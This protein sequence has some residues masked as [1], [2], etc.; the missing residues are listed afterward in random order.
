MVKME[1]SPEFTKSTSFHVDNE[2]LSKKDQGKAPKKSLLKSN[3]RMRNKN[4]RDCSTPLNTTKSETG[5]M[6]DVSGLGDSPDTGYQSEIKSSPGSFSDDGSNKISIGSEEFPTPVW[7]KPYDNSSPDTD[8]LKT[9]KRIGTPQRLF[10]DLDSDNFAAKVLEDLKKRPNQTMGIVVLAIIIFATFITV[11]RLNS[12]QRGHLLKNDLEEL[13]GK[14]W[15]PSTNKGAQNGKYASIEY[16]HEKKLKQDEFKIVDEY[17]NPLGGKKAAI[18]FAYDM[19]RTELEKSNDR[20][21]NKASIMLNDNNIPIE[22]E[23]SNYNAESNSSDEIS[24]NE[25][26][27]YD[28]LQLLDDLKQMGDLLKQKSFESKE[29]Q[30]ENGSVE[31]AKLK[32]TVEEEKLKKLRSFKS[33]ATTKLRPLDLEKTSNPLTIDAKK[34]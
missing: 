7:S 4:S 25:E 16:A 13:Q 12:I 19:K 23:V 22:K 30:L 28:A 3:F 31:A 1:S 34:S 15:T 5:K 10:N 2:M 26:D 33:F 21:E 11:Y 6:H 32:T 9:R 14:F 27:F 18:Q 29:P 8:S 24:D 17:G 20:I